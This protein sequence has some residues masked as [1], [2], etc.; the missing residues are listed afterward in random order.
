MFVCVLVT[1]VI[2]PKTAKPIDRCRFGL[3]FVR[4]PKNEGVLYEWHVPTPVEQWMHSV[5]LFAVGATNNMQQGRRS[6]RG[7]ASYR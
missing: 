6:R 5:F 2:P 7:D 4:I 3:D 1:I